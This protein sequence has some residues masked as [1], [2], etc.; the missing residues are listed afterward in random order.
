ME[1]GKAARWLFGPEPVGPDN[2]GH[3]L[4]RWIFL[5]CLGLIYFS[6]FYSLICQIKGLIGPDGILPARDYLP[7]VAR[8]YPNWQRFWVAPTLFWA[9]TGN[10]FLM[11]VCWLGIVASFLAILNVWPR[12]TLTI[13]FL[14]FLAFV[15]AARD[16]SSYQF[17][18]MLLEAG[19]IS[20]FFAPSGLRPGF[21]RH[22]PPS[23][24]SL[25]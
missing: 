15:A 13:C 21:G 18:G 25:L 23:R 4:A 22:H 10:H 12:T 24:A 16:F 3:L 19:F 9:S 1:A 14:C 2:R 11:F 5:R 7:L 8:A 17:D 20:L 6:A